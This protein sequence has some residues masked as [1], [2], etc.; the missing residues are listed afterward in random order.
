MRDTKVVADRTGSG[1]P[2]RIGDSLDR[3]SAT[4]H[5]GP[6]GHRV[7]CPEF[8]GRVVQLDQLATSFASAVGG[9]SAAVLVSGEAGVGKTRLLDEF[10]ARTRDEGALV[11]TGGCIPI[12]GGGLAYGPVVGIVR[13]IV[14]RIG[15]SEA[16]EVLGPLA[17][18]LSAAMPAADEASAV[19][20]VGSISEGVAKTRLFEA[21]LAAL[22]NLSERSPVVI[23]FEDLHWADSG[24]TELLS[25]LIRNLADA[26][27][28]LVATYRTEEV[29]RDHALRPW[30]SEMGRQAGVT[31][32]T[33]AGFDREETTQLIAGILGHLPDWT[34]VDAVWA[35]SEGNAFFAEELVAARHTPLLSRELQG[36]I[37]ARVDGLSDEAQLVLR[38]ASVGGSSMSHD[39]L[40]RV[41][42][43]GDDVMERALA[44][45]IDRQVLV[46]DTSDPAYRFRH[47]LLREAVYGSLLP[48]ERVRL[49]GQVA[50]ALDADPSL[51]PSDPGHLVAELAVHWFAAGE[52]DA[53]LRESLAAADATA[54]VWASPETLV[55]LERALAALDRLPADRLPPDLDRRALLERT[56][57][58]A[59]WAAASQ[60][61]VDLVLQAID[62]ADVSADPLGVARSY[63]LL[64]RNAWS[65]A[66]SDAAFEAYHRAAELVPPDSPSALLAL[67]QAEEARG[68]M[69][70]SRYLESEARC[71][72]GLEVARAV[73]ARAEEGHLICT[74]GCDLGCTG[75]HDEGI[76]LV[77]EALAIAEEVGTAD[78]VNRAYMCL[79]S[80]LM[81]S[82]Q[83][84]ESVAVLYDAAAV[85]EELWGVRLNGA[86]GNCV[87]ALTWLGRL[88]EAEA[89]VTLIGRQG[90]G[91]CTAGPSTSR[92]DIATRRGRFDEAAAQL[93][94]AD[95]LTLGLSDVQTRGY[96]H[97]LRADLMLAAGRPDEASEE[98]DLALAL[99][100]GTDD[101]FYAP[102]MLANAVRCRADQYE[103]AR[104]SG[105]SFDLDKAQLLAR[106]FEQ[107]A[108][109]LVEA[110]R[111][112]GGTPAPRPAAFAVQCAAERSRLHESDP[113]LWSRA[114]SAWEVAGEPMGVAYCQWREAEARLEDRS[115]RARGGGVLAARVA[116][117]HG[118]GHRPVDGQDRGPGP[119]GA[120][121]AARYRGLRDA[122]H[123][124]HRERSG[125]HAEG[126]RGPRS[127][128]GRS[129]RRRDRRGAVHQ[130]ED[131]E[132]PR[133]E[134]PAQARRGQPGRGGRGGPVP[135]PRL[136]PARQSTAP[137][138]RA[139]RP[140]AAVTPAP[141]SSATA[142]LHHRRDWRAPKKH[143]TPTARPATPPAASSGSSREARTMTTVKAT[144]IAQPTCRL[145]SVS[146]A[147]P[148]AA[149]AISL[150][151][152]PGY[153]GRLTAQDRK[154]QDDLHP[155]GY[156]STRSMPRAIWIAR[157][158]LAV[159]YPWELTRYSIPST[160]QVSVRCPA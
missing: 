121:R 38:V 92:A 146:M 18:G 67:V 49:H 74:L 112:R 37:V 139:S 160:A 133:V 13:D 5:T 30:L 141:V 82:G 27:V 51:G 35:R 108:E 87:D 22:V 129:S 152:V 4:R 103:A 9:R 23:G 68:L 54:A 53:A 20:A 65:I 41:G 91:N 43:L 118:D 33:L 70:L 55:H 148:P 111:A 85:G 34:L 100:V 104:A 45:A 32:I 50:A 132:R 11:A 17:S 153:S 28:L 52:W 6:M 149:Q 127:A 122:R 19:Y 26:P 61:S 73:G 156:G 44:E 145:V 86:S 63:L 46:V 2:V 158:S 12:E 134:H 81:E 117:I 59:Y 94:L 135:R 142:S 107:E 39:L 97:V 14:R 116:R 119:P 58:A 7:S 102:Q 105:R 8:V 56:A 40:V 10:F 29:S 47:N 95:E 89:L 71:R 31:P 83:L 90:I 114:T 138:R 78:A 147:Q 155:L 150:C 137:G 125:A 151:L 25:F 110:P 88:D 154:G 15:P 96:F 136:T 42:G 64:G 84:E 143:A 66:D 140:V 80:L 72:E 115:D 3:R 75:H 76:R 48:G 24:T 123:P 60:R 62:E 36:V 120:D 157:S 21:I 99:A 98:I 101:E 130:Q 128:R 126:G 113:D 57:D 131:G 159:P 144:T 124:D 1:C 77:R 79:T 109:R 93:A 106:G 69:L 16:S